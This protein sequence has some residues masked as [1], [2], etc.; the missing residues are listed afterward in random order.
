MRYWMDMDEKERADITRSM[1]I[2]FI[3]LM[4][5][6]SLFG[7]MTYEGARS[8]TGPFL[9]ILGANA[10]VVGF[11]AGF[12]E[13]VGYGLRF[14][15]GY[16]ADRT[17]RYWTVVIIGYFINMLAVPVLCFSKQWEVAA[18]L[19]IA[20]RMGKAV[21][22]P[23][24]DA[25]L[26]H[27]AHSTGTGWGFGLHEALDQIGAI[28][29][30]LIVAVVL[31]VRGEYTSGFAVLFIPAVL[32]LSVLLTARFL[33]PR[34]QDLELKT[35][36]LETKGYVPAFWLYIAAVACIAMGYA[37]FPLIAFH[38]KKTA[39]L[40]D[41]MIPIIYAAAMGVDGLT[42]L[43]A[44][45]LYDRFGIYTLMASVIVSLFF[46]PFVFLGGM[47]SVFIGVVLWGIGLGAQESIVRA[48]VADL[49][50]QDKRATAYGI[51]NAG[52]GLFWFLGSALMGILYTVSIPSVIVFSVVTQCC[53]VPIMVLVS[54]R[55]K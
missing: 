40:S 39:V 8:I 22:A 45:R 28:I 29:G 12:G 44:G 2:K 15:S 14:V 25:M 7:D 46:A 55:I 53:S 5:I 27:A 3:V 49:T 41:N 32:C 38:F 54:R 16:I 9:G 13:L 36:R 20:E 21:R 33:Y 43:I 52:Y 18:A 50:Q 51:F 17:K 34:P 31:S 42:A 24:R 37:D 48:V 47:K 4:G 30:P 6:V 11:V 35:T 1:G 19:I 23:A 26:S 10:A